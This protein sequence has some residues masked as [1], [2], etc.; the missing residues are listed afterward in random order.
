MACLLF[1]SEQ[2][3]AQEEPPVVE[4]EDS[5]IEGE[6]CISSRPIRKT[7][8]LD[9]QNILFYM[10]GAGIYLN[11]LPKPC[12]RLAQESRFMYRTTVA[13]LCR[14]DMINILN[15]TG[16]GLSAGRGCKLGNF[17]AITQED[18]EKIKSPPEVEPK[19]I[20]PATP[21]EPGTDDGEASTTEDN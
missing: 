20:P 16:L 21:E 13:R 1:Q 12:K 9:D 7:E 19:P 6:R 18:V 5:I 2:A 17:Y 11:H 14:A 8:V 4:D 15:D 10:R 3:T